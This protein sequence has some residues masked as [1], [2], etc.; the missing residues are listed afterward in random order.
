M[1]FQSP[2][3]V[4]RATMQPQQEAMGEAVSRSNLRR[5]V[6]YLGRSTPED[7]YVELGKW[8]FYEEGY[9]WGQ[10]RAADLRHLQ[11]AESFATY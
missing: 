10:N 2:E 3:G 7:L 6:V 9:K 1:V 11:L 8:F 4:A 5:G